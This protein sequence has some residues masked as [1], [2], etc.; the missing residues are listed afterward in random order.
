MNYVPPTGTA[1][2]RAR[3]ATLIEEIR[4]E[5]DRQVAVEGWSAKHDDQHKRGELAR[6]AA[7]YCVNASYNDKVQR[8]RAKHG[9]PPQVWPL[10]WSWSWWKPKDR[11]R[12]LVR[13]AALIVAELERL[14]R[15]G[16][17]L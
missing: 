14:D 12:D 5:R 10:K 4:N 6:A 11:R 3:R 9:Q 7:A 13:A 17:V 8:D 2:A 15:G 1:E 16:K